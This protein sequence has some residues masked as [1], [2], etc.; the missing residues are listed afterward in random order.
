MFLKHNIKKITVFINITPDGHSIVIRWSF[1]S[2]KLLQ[3][4]DGEAKQR[5]W[6]LMG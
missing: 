2:K 5:C 1:S 3:S 4:N 6:H